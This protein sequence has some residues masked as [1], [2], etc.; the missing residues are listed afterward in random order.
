LKYLTKE[1]TITKHEEF[2]SGWPKEVFDE[3]RAVVWS[4]SSYASQEGQ[5]SQ[6]A[7][8]LTQCMSPVFWKCAKQ[9]L[10]SMSTAE[11]ELQMLCEGSL[12]TKNVG[13]LMKEMTKPMKEFVE[14]KETLQELLDKEEFQADEEEPPEG[15]ED[16]LLV[17]NKAATL[18]LVQESGSWRTRHLRVRASSL[19][20]R[21]NSGFQK[22]IHV[23]GRSMLAD[24]NTKS[25]PHSRLA[26][27]RKMWSAERIEQPEPE[28]KESETEPERVEAKMIRIRP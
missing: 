10:V 17:D 27:L 11:A 7:L 15:E 6:G 5:K 2:A 12:A 26:T 4:D 19:K 16:I 23:A 13:M 24:L 3:Q 20:Q 22:V 14:R 18:I 28:S 25:H 21:V 8:V 1:D 9:G